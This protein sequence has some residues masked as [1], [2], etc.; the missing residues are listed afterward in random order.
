MRHSSRAPLV[1]ATAVLWAATAPRAT[2]STLTDSMG[3]A[4]GPRL[5]RPPAT[6]TILGAPPGAIRPGEH[7]GLEREIPPPA[8]PADG[9]VTAATAEPA[10]SQVPE[11]WT[12]VL[13]LVG[14]VF[15][16]PRRPRA[17]ARTSA[18]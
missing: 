17:A 11:P 8:P 16:L 4:D 13:V 2:G 3:A 18:C 14:G 9:L 10:T 6:E 5:K 7:P 1:V 12:F 15:V